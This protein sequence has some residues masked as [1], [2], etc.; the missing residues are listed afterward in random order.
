MSCTTATNAVAFEYLLEYQNKIED[1]FSYATLMAVARAGVS[2]IVAAV[3]A[4]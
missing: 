4:G 2:L 1:Y 3:C